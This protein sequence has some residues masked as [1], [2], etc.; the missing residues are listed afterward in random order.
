[1]VKPGPGSAVLL[2]HRALAERNRLWMKQAVKHLNAAIAGADTLYST[3]HFE[4]SGGLSGLG[5]VIEYVARQLNRLQGLPDNGMRAAAAF[6]RDIDAALLG[7]LQRGR[8]AGTWDLASGITGVG[9][10]F[11]QGLPDSMAKFG[12][13]LVMAHLGEAAKAELPFATTGDVLYLAEETGEAGVA[14][15]QADRLRAVCTQSLLRAQNE[16]WRDE[17]SAAPIVSQRR[18]HSPELAEWIRHALERCLQVAPADDDSRL[19]SMAVTAHLWSRIYR[20]S[21][22]FRCQAAALKWWERAIECCETDARQMEEAEMKFPGG[23]TDVGLALSAAL[24][25]IDAEWDTLLCLAPQG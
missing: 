6:N 25:P 4:F 14:S 9:V 3:R 21:E 13:E 7:E 20:S 18:P 16:T 5:W 24:M 22:N 11:L 23:S 12:L 2:A 8:W 10:Y 17:L 1:M 15:A 19:Q